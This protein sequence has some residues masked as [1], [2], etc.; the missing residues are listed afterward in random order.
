[1]KTL[2]LIVP[3][4]IGAKFEANVRAFLADHAELARIILP[5]LEAWRS[6]RITF[7]RSSQDSLILKADAP[8]LSG[9]QQCRSLRCAA[10]MSGGRTD[11]AS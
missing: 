3:R 2:G 10:A 9:E 6:L 7:G 8:T 4:G 1:M 11:A 5:L